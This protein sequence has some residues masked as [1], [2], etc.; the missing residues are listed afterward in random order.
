MD[1][2]KANRA[3]EQLTWATVDSYKA[4][5]NLAGALLEQNIRFTSGMMLDGPIEVLHRQAETN[6]A[7]GQAL[8]EQYRRQIETSQDLLLGA[9]DACMDLLFVPL[10]NGGSEE[11]SAFLQR[12]S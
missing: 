9:V 11:A 7:M 5:T 6:R 4:L 10:P 1:S 8:A 2:N 3:G 12:P